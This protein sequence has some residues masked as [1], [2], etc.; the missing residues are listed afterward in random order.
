[1]SDFV[2][3]RSVGASCS[4]RTDGRLDGYDKANSRFSQFFRTRLIRYHLKYLCTL[5]LVYNDPTQTP[6]FINICQFISD[7]NQTLIF[8]E[9]KP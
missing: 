5:L 8:P 2:E 7:I 4:M 9:W 1:M 3:I 6:S